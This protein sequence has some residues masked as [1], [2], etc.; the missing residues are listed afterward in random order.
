MAKKTIHTSLV[1]QI[2]KSISDHKGLDIKT[3]NVSDH[4]SFTDF[5]IIAT[6]TSSTH[7]QA[8][9]NAVTE[10]IPVAA[11]KIEGYSS[12]EWIIV[13]VGDIVVHVFQS[14][15]RSFYNLDK[16]WSHA[17]EVAFAKTTA[18]KLKSSTL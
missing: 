10:V 5:F 14:T 16:L 2:T 1:N 6:A 13:D 12:G 4:C 18:R 11:S 8:L 17:S 15:I 9:C 7:A 3:L